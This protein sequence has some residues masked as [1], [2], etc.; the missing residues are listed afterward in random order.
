M[1]NP[2]R[3]EHIE[4]TGENPNRTERGRHEGELQLLLGVTLLSVPNG[5]ERSSA[6]LANLQQCQ[7][8]GEA[9]ETHTA[10][11]PRCL[12]R[13]RDCCCGAS[14]LVAVLGILRSDRAADLRGQFPGHC[15]FNPGRARDLSFNIRPATILHSGFLYLRCCVQLCRCLASL[16]LGVRPWTTPCPDHTAHEVIQ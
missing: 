5:A 13:R 1:G 6:G 4:V 16:A 3:P 14:V 9:H 15:S 8:F 7:W 11:S 10:R 2:T 12:S